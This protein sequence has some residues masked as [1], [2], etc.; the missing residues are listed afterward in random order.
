MARIFALSIVEINLAWF[1]VHGVVSSEVAKGFGEFV[2]RFISLLAPQGLSIC[3]AFDIPEHLLSAPIA[4]DWAKYNETDNQGIRCGICFKLK[5][6]SG[7]VV[8]Y[9]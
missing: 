9:V 1:L 3:D 6:N 8:V 4:Q 7:W 5:V 2:C